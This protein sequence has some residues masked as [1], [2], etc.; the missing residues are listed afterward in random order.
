M[1][2]DL[3]GN[4][5]NHLFVDAYSREGFVYLLKQKSEAHRSLRSYIQD[6]N[7]PGTIRTGAKELTKGEF[8]KICLEEHITQEETCRHTPQQIGIAERRLTVLEADAKAMC[9]NADLPYSQFWG[10]AQAA[11]NHVRNRVLSKVAGR[12]TMTPYQRS[13]GEKPNVSHLRVF[14]CVAFVHHP[15]SARNKP[16]FLATRGIF[17]GIQ[18]SL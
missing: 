11:A 7:A 2:A 3:N 8:A 5:R 9:A 12:P 13:T 16:D 6:N 1:P 10:Y 17:V 15:K 4:V 18:E 14:G